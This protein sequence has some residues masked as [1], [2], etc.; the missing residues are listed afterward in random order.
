MKTHMGESM[1]KCLGLLTA[2]VFLS[3]CVALTT[4]LSEN[5][6]ESSRSENYLSMYRAKICYEASE[7]MIGLALRAF[8][9]TSIICRCATSTGQIN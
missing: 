8:F 9:M 2:G 6:H 7:P 4:Q 5:E 3:A 1:R